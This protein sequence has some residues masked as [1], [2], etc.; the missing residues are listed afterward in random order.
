ML[1]KE[2]GISADYMME[3]GGLLLLLFGGISYTI[4]ALVYYLLKKKKF[5]H[6]VFHM[7]V[8]AGSILHA[9]Y[10]MLYII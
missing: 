8:L 5:A 7:F 1:E 2:K 3:K 4:G 10:V 9:L 6:S